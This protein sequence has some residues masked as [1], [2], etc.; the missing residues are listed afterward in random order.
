M[1][2]AATTAL[3]TF[4]D[5]SVLL[6]LMLGVFAGLVIGVIPGLGGTA[7]VALLLPF[8]FVLEPEQAI[9]LII[10]S[11]GTVHT[12]D[13]ITA[14]LLGV[15]GSAPATVTILDG[16]AM[17]KQGQAA[18][19][20]SIAFLSSM[21]GGLLGAI[22]LT[23]SIPAVR[24]LVLSFASPELFLLTFMGVALTAVLSRGN[25]VKG[26]VAGALG[27]LLGTV[28]SAPAVLEYRYTFGSDFLLDGLDLVAVALGIYGIAEIAHLVARRTGIATA[29]ALGGGWRQGAQ[30]VRRNWTDV[31]R[32]SFIGMWAGVLPGIGATGGAWMAYGQTVATSKDKQSFGKGNPRGIVAPESANNSV[33]AG[34]LVPTLLFGIPGAPSAALLLGALLFYGIEPGPRIVTNDLDVL[35]TIIYSLALASIL[36]AALCFLITRPLARISGVPFPKLAPA[37][38]TIMFVAAYQASGRLADILLMLGLGIAGYAM[39]LTG[40]PRAP[41]LIGFVLAL[42]LERYYF[43]TASLYDGFAW[44][45]RPLVRVLLAVLLL[46]LLAMGVRAVLRRGR[47][48]E[49][50]VEDEDEEPYRATYLPTAVAAVLLALFVGAFVLAGGFAPNAR[51]M[52]NL[53]CIIG[54]AFA[55]FALVREVLRLVRN[56]ARGRLWDDNLRTTAVSF[57]WIGLFLAL[58]AGLGVLLAAAV[59]VPLFLWRV[60]EVRLRGVVL[61]TSVLIG[62]LI[63]A[64]T[65]LAVLL[66]EGAVQALGGR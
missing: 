8:I 32:G 25:M 7:A 1:L 43:L 61:Y 33:Q 58:L 39:K 4:L 5:P 31:L 36:G 50:P 9:V 34:D 65:Y 48:R 3:S 29:V 12:S 47:P 57:V 19:A 23:L 63:I 2:D 66:P 15:P 49:A 24:P 62:L 64:S 56:R 27:L 55:S 54:I 30:D 13:T 20:L 35:F 14:V 26:I 11:V 41:L 46:P 17:A 16:H 44:M 22:G 60:A 21:A 10:G 51:L 28:G 52:P 40:F 37:L 18:R 53:V 6:F 42:P 59:F 45:E 38:I